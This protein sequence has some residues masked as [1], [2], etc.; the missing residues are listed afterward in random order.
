[1]PT[2]EEALF[3]VWY[4]Y[5]RRA[6]VLAPKLE[7]RLVWLPNRWKHRFLRPLDY[8][9][10]LVLTIRAIRERRPRFVI[11]QS[12]PPFGA[13]AAM[14]LRVP[15]ALDA[16]NASLQGFWARLPLAGA[17]ARGAVVVVAHNH[18]AGAIAHARFPGA[19]VTVLRDPL[20]EE[21]M[22]LRGGARDPNR[23]LTICSF[24]PDEPIPLIHDLI[25][26]RRDLEFVITARVERL[27]PA[28]RERFIR[29][30]NLRLTGFL[31]TKD[32]N[33]LLKTSGAAVVFTT[34]TATQPSGACEALAADTP[35][36]L[37]RTS[38]TQALFGGWAQLVE[39]DV[40]Q[41]SSAIDRARFSRPD[42]SRPRADWMAAFQEELD[43]LLS[44]LT[45]APYSG[46]SRSR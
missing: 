5:Q 36:V 21:L 23:I 31:P 29:L 16:H 26:R 7:A 8:L 20:D 33:E 6:E 41:V 22:G 37:S 18:E 43:D 15:Y 40:E 44:R 24:G 13:L 9:R 38:L 12:P 30:P 3:I 46:T 25:A 32:Y 17:I 39:H 45:G 1:M 19:A 34:R 4:G 27:P 11:L 14:A 42:L 35:L 10:K 2:S 28:W